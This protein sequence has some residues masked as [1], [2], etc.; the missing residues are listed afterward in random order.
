MQVNHSARGR[1]KRPVA[2]VTPRAERYNS[3][4]ADQGASEQR[5]LPSELRR[6]SNEELLSSLDQVLL[7]LERR[8]FRYAHVGAEL[9]QMADEGLLLSSR[10]A[11]RL[12]QA[13]SAAGH[14]Q[15]HLQVV[16][17]GEW[18]PRSTRPTWSDDP[19]VQGS[20]E[21]PAGEHQGED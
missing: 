12:A 16:G 15:G 19:R 3:P 6:L 10:S 13:Q 4:V 1:V 21:D 5:D 9:Q 18:S 2:A 17:V 11:A 8:L 20:Q 14:A 7:E